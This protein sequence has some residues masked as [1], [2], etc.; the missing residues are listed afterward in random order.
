MNNKAYVSRSFL[1]GFFK[2]GSLNCVCGIIASA[3]LFTQIVDI[4]ET[5]GLSAFPLI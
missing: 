3:A 2:G 5:A 1:S 4:Y